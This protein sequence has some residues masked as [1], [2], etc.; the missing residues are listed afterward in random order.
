M[1][2]EL[3]SRYAPTSSILPDT[4]DL[5]DLV[6][7]FVAL[8]SG[9]T[10]SD[11]NLSCAIQGELV[12]PSRAQPP[13]T[14]N[15]GSSPQPC[16]ATVLLIDSKPSGVSETLRQTLNE[17]GVPV[18]RPTVFSTVVNRYSV[19]W[20]RQGA[21]NLARSFRTWA[22][23]DFGREAAEHMR[24]T[25]YNCSPLRQLDGVVSTDWEER[26][27]LNL[28]IGYTEVLALSEWALPLDLDCSEATEATDL[29]TLES[30][31]IDICP[32]DQDERTVTV[33]AGGST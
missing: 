14:L 8:G 28:T 3:L 11:G 12:T 13:T 30:A 10:D 22:S 19:Q 21:R 7:Y 23:S 31:E 33:T 27:G 4:C 20:F 5:E 32:V 18:E 26:S 25:F 9:F 24:L 15:S 29:R 16:F 2:P 1:P 6:R 17:R